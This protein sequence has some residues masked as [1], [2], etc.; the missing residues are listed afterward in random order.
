MAFIKL[1]PPLP[2]FPSNLIIFKQNTT[3]FHW[4]FLTRKTL[5]SYGKLTLQGMELLTAYD[6]ITTLAIRI[7]PKNI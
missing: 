6:V 1:Q 2:A 3:I 5:F 7:S 4:T